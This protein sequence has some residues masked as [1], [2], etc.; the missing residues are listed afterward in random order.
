MT[1][2]LRIL[3]WMRT[4][5]ASQLVRHL[6]ACDIYKLE[7][8]NTLGITRTKLRLIRCRARMGMN[9]RDRLRDALAD[10]NLVD[11]RD[12]PPWDPQAVQ[13]VQ[14]QQL[15]QEAAASQP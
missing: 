14:Q 3:L 6:F 11:A 9:R 4:V 7:T 5:L 13:Q 2:R 12:P 8:D 1:F 10:Q 15:Q